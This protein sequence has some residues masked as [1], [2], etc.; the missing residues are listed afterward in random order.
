VGYE[1]AL[2][3][4]FVATVDR[5]PANPYGPQ[6]ETRPVNISPQQ[7]QFIIDHGSNLLS[8][9]FY[10]SLFGRSMDVLRPLVARS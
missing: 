4:E 3:L 1:G 9:E 6:V 2:S 8:A 10:S 5:T 7:R